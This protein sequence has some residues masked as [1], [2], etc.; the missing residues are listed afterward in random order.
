[1]SKGQIS[2]EIV[3]AVGAV[4]VLFLI[5]I[6]LTFV[7]KQEALDTEKFIEARAECVAL[8]DALSS[9]A[10]LGPVSNVTMH[11][12]YKHSISNTSVIKSFVNDSGQEIAFCNY[13]GVVGPYTNLSGSITIQ[14]LA[15]NVSVIQG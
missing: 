10:T 12:Y 11:V 6:A 2:L 9:M 3:F 5:I 8:A 1:M 4:L 14:N 7:K 15:G 13:L